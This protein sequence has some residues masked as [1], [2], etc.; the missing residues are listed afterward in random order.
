MNEEYLKWVI[1]E[2]RIDYVVHGD[3]PCIVN[4]KDVYEVAQKLGKYR[5][6][7]R[8][9]G[10]STTDIV[11]RMLLMSK[12]QIHKKKGGSPQLVSK[13]AK[14]D[15]HLK[16]ICKT[17]KFL[18]TS[19]M[20][21]LFS[22]GVKA[23]PKGAK[24]VYIDGAW[25]LFHAG[26]VM[27]FKKAR[28]FGDYLIVGVQ[29]DELVNAVRGLNMPLMTMNERVLSVLGC[30]A[31]DDV[32]IDSPWNTSREMIASLNISTVLHAK[33]N[34]FREE[35]EQACQKFGDPYKVPMEMNIFHIIQSPLSITLTDII[36]RIQKQQD[37]F[38]QKIAK[39]KKTEDDYYANR[40]GFTNGTNS[41][42]GAIIN[43]VSST[44]STVRS[45]QNG[46]NSR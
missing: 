8:T 40:Y 12:S 27:T 30:R 19:R 5:T 39:K 17:S 22:A 2:Y 7:P 23:P 26:H 35:F 15:G 32:L 3:D 31:V 41:T 1:K 38:Q 46:T 42:L 45:A 13:N 6:I 16:E 20:L 33:L 36:D 10:V 34:E 24:V 18:T 9:E 4:G 11:G 21:R 44:L 43:Q 25:D 37:M 29:N 14:D 28:E